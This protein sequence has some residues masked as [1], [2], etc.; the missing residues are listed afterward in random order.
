[1]YDVLLVQSAV[2]RNQLNPRG[3]RLA[4]SAG[5]SRHYR[6]DEVLGRHFAQPARV[7]GLGPTLI[8]KVITGVREKAERAP[9]AARSVMPGDFADE[10]HNSI[11][12]AIAARLGRLDT[13]FA[14]LG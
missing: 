2:D 6:V 7:A 4:M 8:K 14:E 3:F 9:D 11:R 10:I 1:M 13:A 5:K 12:A